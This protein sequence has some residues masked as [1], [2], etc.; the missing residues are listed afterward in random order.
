MPSSNMLSKQFG[1]YLFLKSRMKD[2]SF[3]LM[4]FAGFTSKRIQG[5]PNVEKD[6]PHGH[7]WDGPARCN[8]KL[9]V[10]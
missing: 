6:S 8:S 5:A 7:G 9:I 3:S 10:G 2:L 4:L 1:G